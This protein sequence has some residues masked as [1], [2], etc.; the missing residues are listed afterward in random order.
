MSVRADHE[1]LADGVK[2]GIGSGHTLTADLLGKKLSARVTATRT[3]YD[4]A[5]VT[6]DE[7]GPVTEGI[8]TPSTPVIQDIPIVGVPLEVRQASG[9]S[10]QWLADGREIQGADKDVFTPTDAE[11]GKT[12]TVRITRAK[13]GYVTLVEVSAPSEA[14]VASG[15]LPIDSVSPPGIFGLTTVGEDLQ[16]TEGQ[17]QP[18]SVHHPLDYDYQWLAD[19]DPIP[20][21]TTFHLVPKTEHLGKRLSV[22]VTANRPGYVSKSVTTA[23]TAPITTGTPFG[24]PRGFA[25]TGTTVTS[26]DL[27]WREVDGAAKYRVSY[28]PSASTGSFTTVDVGG[29][30]R[31][32]TGLKPNTEYE[33]RVAAV[34]ADGQLSPYSTI[35]ISTRQLVAPNN[36]QVASQTPTSVTLEW[37]K[38]PGVPKYRM[39]YGIGS[40][41]RTRVEVGDVSTKTITGLKP[42]TP[43]LIDI[44]SLL[45]DGTRSSYSPKITATTDLFLPPTDLASPGATSTTIDLTWTKAPSAAKYRIAYGIESG[46]RTGFDVGNISSYR[47]TGLKPGTTYTINMRAM[48]S[49]GTRSPYTSLISVTT[50]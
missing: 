20:G 35:W 45:N 12:L 42:N 22:T 26:I 2:V 41:T 9:H 33:L 11:L 31:T 10:Y 50:D 16:V 49:D 38:V 48:M 5:T 3:G 14:V 28:R 6:T 24:V 36:L 32:L 17:W 8:F 37:T 34:R 15:T 43:Y 21:A 7:V 25:L 18:E 30:T 1:L 23:E 44:A 13:P 39:Y 19:G 47:L 27:S 4:P 29:L 40:G 46:T